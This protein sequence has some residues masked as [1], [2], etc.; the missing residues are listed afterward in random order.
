MASVTM[1]VTVEPPGRQDEL[2]AKLEEVAFRADDW[3]LP[4]REIMGL[5][6]RD[7][8]RHFRSLRG[9]YVLTGATRASLTQPAANGAIRELHAGSLHFGSSL[10]TARYLTKSPHDP[11]NEQ[12]P[13][14]HRPDLLS[15]VLV[16]RGVTKKE[17]SR[18]IL[19]HTAEPW[20]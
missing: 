13:K 2:A 14:P 17:A 15:G 4:F 3:R 11:F 19:E 5:L 20:D 12:V 18:I 16:F 10:D 7:E 6:E 1:E 8:A 9:R